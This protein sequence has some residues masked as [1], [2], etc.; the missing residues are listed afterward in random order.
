M[1]RMT[2][3]EGFARGKPCIPGRD[4]LGAESILFCFSVALVLTVSLVSGCSEKVPENFL[5]S[6]T[7]ES[8]EVRVSS[9][10]AGKLVSVSFDE[11]DRVG[12]GDTLAVVDT[13]NMVIKRK[14]LLAT[15]DKLEAS[16]KEVVE[17]IKRAGEDLASIEKKLKRVERLL[18]TG[19]ATQQQYDDLLTRYNISESRLRSVRMKLETL[20]ADE[21]KVSASIELLNKQI[22]DAVITSPVSGTIARKYVEEGE[23]VGA[24]MPICKVD[25]TDEF[26]LRI[27][28]SE[29]MLGSIA[30]GDTVD[31]RV[32]GVERSFRGVVSWV[33]PEAEFTPKN[34]QTKDSRAELVYAVKIR[35]VEGSRFF[36][37]GMPAEVYSRKI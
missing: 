24:G 20:K 22:S 13:T 2:F 3:R 8:K 25:C 23:I 33:S 34:V 37:I 29:T 4:L 35:L 36:K 9:L 15:L 11:G 27:F 7:L 6:G 12:E 28:V 1:F 16:R 19:S 32:D 14:E 18:S 17:E 30:I 21:A 10:V 31:V 5:G 26:W